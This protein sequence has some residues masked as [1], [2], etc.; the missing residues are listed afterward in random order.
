[1]KK[2]CYQGRN[3]QNKIRF[4]LINKAKK[5]KKKMVNNSVIHSRNKR[6]DINIDSMDILNKIYKYYDYLYN[7]WTGLSG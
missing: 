3:H 6:V 4:F 1:M 5:K 2:K 7:R